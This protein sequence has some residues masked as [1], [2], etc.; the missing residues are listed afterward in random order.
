MKLKI[1]LLI[2]LAGSS[3]FI[4]QTKPHRNDVSK[5]S[6]VEAARLVGVGVVAEALVG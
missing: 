1:K 5:V 4:I 3:S 2:Y 6:G